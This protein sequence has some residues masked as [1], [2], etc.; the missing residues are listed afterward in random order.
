MLKLTAVP[1]PR[2]TDRGNLF[3]RLSPRT[4]RDLFDMA[5]RRNGPSYDDFDDSLMSGSDVRDVEFLPL[6]ISFR[7]E[8]VQD[9]QGNITLY[10]SYN[11]G[12][13]ASASLLSSP[14]CTGENEMYYKT[15]VSQL[16]ELFLM[17]NTKLFF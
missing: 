12:A 4:A 5:L 7:V 10:A 9:S 2:E 16:Y 8:D 15:S 14:Y 13:P 1:R 6:E 17:M 3:V 11:G